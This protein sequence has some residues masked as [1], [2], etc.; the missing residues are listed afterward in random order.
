MDAEQV[1]KSLAAQFLAKGN[2]EALGSALSYETARHYAEAAALDSV[3]EYFIEEKGFAEL[4]VH[5]VG[6]TQGA[7]EE[8]VVIYVTRG[9][10]RR[11]K[12]LPEEVEGVEVIARVMGKMRVGPAPATARLGVSYFFEKNGRIACGSSCAP[13]GETYSGTLG[14]LLSDGA[15]Q[16]ALSNNHVFGACNHTPVGI[17]MLAP[18][19]SDARPDR[20]APTSFSRYERMIELRSGDPVLVEPMQ[21]DA[22]VANVSDP[23]LVSSWQGDENGYDTPTTTAQPAAGMK[24]KKFGRTTSLTVGEIEAFVPTPWVLPYRSAKF[25]ATVWFTDT[26]TVKSVDS[27]PFALPGD[28][29]SLIV[30]DNNN[31]AVGLLFAVNNRGEYGIF[32]PIEQVLGGFGNMRLLGGHGV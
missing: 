16:F 12:E 11:L 17:P 14:A 29:G 25:T 15:R 19:G 31:A 4:A 2:Y 32:M 3:D 1:A 6:Y 28:S 22:A 27:E 7:D 21:L 20:R 18:S 23:N 10:K 24:V 9:S 30:T 8:K 13:S 5:S 26:W